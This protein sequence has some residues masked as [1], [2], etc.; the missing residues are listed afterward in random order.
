MA[1][2]M[3]TVVLCDAILPPSSG[4]KTLHL[5]MEAVCSSKTLVRLYKSRRRRQPQ[6]RH[7]ETRLLPSLMYSVTLWVFRCRREKSRTVAV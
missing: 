5:K 6:D 3:S 7:G 2:K 1:V 4:V